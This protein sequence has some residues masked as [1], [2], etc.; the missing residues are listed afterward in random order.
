[1]IRE[2]WAW[3]FWRNLQVDHLKVAE[4]NGYLFNVETTIKMLHF[5]R[6]SNN[7][8]CLLELQVFMGID[9]WPYVSPLLLNI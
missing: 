9:K 8:T 6:A 5:W 3:V 7:L 1:M 4:Q 2:A